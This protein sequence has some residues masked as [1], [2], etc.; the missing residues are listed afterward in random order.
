MKRVYISC[1]GIIPALLVLISII[2]AQNLTAK[3]GV[4]KTKSESVSK[5]V[6]ESD[7]G[8][9]EKQIVKLIEKTFDEK[10]GSYE[11]SLNYMHWWLAF[12]VVLVSIT[13]IFNSIQAWRYSSKEIDLLKTEVKQYEDQLKKSKER[14]DKEGSK[15]DKI[16]SDSTYGGFY[17]LAL[18]IIE[19][20]PEKSDHKT[21]DKIGMALS[22]LRLL[23]EKDFNLLYVCRNISLCHKKLGNYED[24][25]KYA[26]EGKGIATEEKPSF[27]GYF[28]REIAEIKQLTNKN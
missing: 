6:R 11:K 2:Y 20:I 9:S 18:N 28:D 21:E 24:A 1:I 13:P 14:L 25:L 7:H 26:K 8:L 4:L 17:E 16:I 10:Y 23:Y 12:L 3:T 15:T 27:T 19:E 5:S 22:Y